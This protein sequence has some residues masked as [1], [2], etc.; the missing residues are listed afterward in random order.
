MGWGAGEKNACSAFGACPA[1]RLLGTPARLPHTPMCVLGSRSA[2]PES[3][4]ATHG[5]LIKKKTSGF[6]GHMPSKQRQQHAKSMQNHA[7]QNRAKRARPPAH[8]RR[9]HFRKNVEIRKWGNAEAQNRAKRAILP[10]R[11]CTDGLGECESPTKRNKSPSEQMPPEN[12]RGAAEQQ[13]WTRKKRMASW[14][15]QRQQIMEAAAG[16]ARACTADGAVALTDSG[17]TRCSRART[18]S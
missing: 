16:G 1:Q 18:G 6:G 9:G 4:F 13:N 2:R 10:V 11:N 3:R 8:I 7:T 15:R 14:A 12:K 5:S 17:P